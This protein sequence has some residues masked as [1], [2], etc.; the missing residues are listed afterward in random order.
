MV[1]INGG[2]K[3]LIVDDD[4]DNVEIIGMLLES[5]GYEVLT[6]GCGERCFEILEE[7]TPDLI[8]LDV[9]MD[10]LTEGFDVGYRLKNQPEYHS[11]PVVLV[12]AIGKHAGFPVDKKSI[13]VDDYLEKPVNPDVLLNCI[14]KLIG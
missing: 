2:R 1:T 10:T 5:E 14:R 4:R 12:T 9:M 7:T 3:I 6:A 8:I 11:I 13:R